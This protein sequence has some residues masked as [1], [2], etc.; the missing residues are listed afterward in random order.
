MNEADA[1]LVPEDLAAFCKEADALVRAGIP[2]EARRRLNF[3]LDSLRN[4]HR[5]RAQA[6]VL[7]AFAHLDRS[8]GRMAEAES[9]L[10]AALACFL[11]LGDRAGE[12]RLLGEL[13]SM[14]ISQ[15]DL[16]DAAFWLQSSLEVMKALDDKPGLAEIHR[17]LAVLH[18][19]KGEL[20]PAEVESARAIDLFRSLDD[21]LGEARAQGLLAQILLRR[22]AFSAAHEAGERARELFEEEGH[23]PGVSSAQMIIAAILR[24]EGRLAEAEALLTEVL[25]EKRAMQDRAGE[26]GVLNTLGLVVKDSGKDRLKDAERHLLRAIELFLELNDHQNAAMTQVNLG[27]LYDD[28]GRSED[29]EEVIRGALRLHRQTGA[30]ESEKRIMRE[31]GHTLALLGRLNDA[32]EAFREALDFARGHDDGSMAPEFL[33]D[34]AELQLLRGQLASVREV[35]AEVRRRSPATRAFRIKYVLPTLARI[36]LAERDLAGARAAVTE[37]EQALSKEA[38]EARPGLR[39]QIDRVARAI[40]A[41]D[42]ADD[43]P[44]YNGYLPSEQ[45]ARVRKALLAELQQA[46]PDALNNLEPELLEAMQA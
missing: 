9:S 44:L 36:A 5:P 14:R 20:P 12:A 18:F 1:D 17:N 33:A 28:L 7:E 22:S 11:K 45:P 10:R 16:E 41:A 27:E 13:A 31:L 37:A 29:A 25:A 4:L 19:R 21:D 23:K 38:E 43:W 2:D 34:W 35:T 32:E 6:L 40:T 39:G 26:A 42:K 15:G 46:N 8:I 24:H 3:A 30:V